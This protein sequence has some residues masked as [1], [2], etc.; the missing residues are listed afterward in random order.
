MLHF[1]TFHNVSICEM[2]TKV[3]NEIQTSVGGLGCLR[4]LLHRRFCPLTV[5]WTNNFDLY[6]NLNVSI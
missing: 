5:I 6:R 1:T 3:S 4:Y 2:P